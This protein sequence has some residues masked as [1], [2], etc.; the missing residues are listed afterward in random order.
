MA[1]Q[2]QVIL[3]N[4]FAVV[5]NE[6]LAAGEA[7]TPGHLMG[8]SSGEWVKHAG[9]GKNAAPWFALER[10]ELG[11]DMDEAYAADDIVKA[12]FCP[13]G[14]HVN[15]WCA[16]GTDLTIGD[17]VESAGDGTLRELG[18][19]AATDQDEREA[20]VG[21]VMEDVGP[22]TELTRVCVVIV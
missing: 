18:V 9:A 13:P 6:D 16:S 8:V 12:G 1:N 22:V 17:Y 3:R 20:T 7:I 15:A 21:M 19:D 11:N 5:H 14:T 2:R 10:D 4:E